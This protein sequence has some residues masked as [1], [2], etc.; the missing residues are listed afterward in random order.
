MGG[1][2]SCP[3]ATSGVDPLKSKRVKRSDSGDGDSSSSWPL[4]S[5]PEEPSAPSR[6]LPAAWKWREEFAA[7]EDPA[8][9]SMAQLAE[10]RPPTRTECS[11]SPHHCDLVCGLEFSLDGRLL[12]AAGVSKQVRLPS[13]DLAAG[14][15]CLRIPMHL[16]TEFPCPWQPCQMGRVKLYLDRSRLVH[17]LC[18]C[19]SPRT[20]PHPLPPC[21]THCCFAAAHR[22][23]LSPAVS[24]WAQLRLYTLESLLDPSLL[25]QQLPVAVVRTFAKVSSL[26]WNPDSDGVVTLGDYD[27][28]LTQVRQQPLPWSGCLPFVACRSTVKW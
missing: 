14:V 13:A 28:V 10:F 7:R 22:P 24:C 3:V 4:C 5:T 21:T 19:Q 15:Q 16:Q 12:V 11:S 6:C 26:A 27:G 17:V 1:S 9:C 25:P 18:V 23:L 8:P 20:T 2:D